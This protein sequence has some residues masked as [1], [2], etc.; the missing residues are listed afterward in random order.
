MFHKEEKQIVGCCGL[1]ISP[2]KALTGNL[3][4]KS[5]CQIHIGDISESLWRK[6]RRGGDHESKAPVTGL[7]SQEER[8]RPE[9]EYVCLSAPSLADPM[10]PSAT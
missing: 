3:L 8:K 7:M 4:S 6:I 5:L 9:R 1:S 2:N 10:M